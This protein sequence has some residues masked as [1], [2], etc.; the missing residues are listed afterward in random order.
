M[1]VTAYGD[2]GGGAVAGGGVWARAPSAKPAAMA[3]ALALASTD[4]RPT[5][6]PPV[7]HKRS[8]A[9]AGRAP[10]RRRRAG[11]VAPTYR[12]FRGCANPAH[13]LGPAGL[14]GT[15]A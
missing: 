6:L 9:L 2:S 7:P 5:M 13:G 8:S 14:S 4:R 10:M 11:L 3:T 1:Y 12:H 15:S